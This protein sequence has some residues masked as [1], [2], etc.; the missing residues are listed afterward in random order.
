MD[1]L[2]EAVQVENDADKRMAEFHQIQ[3]IAARDLPI[4]PLLELQQL[5]LFDK[6]VHDHTTTFDGPFSNLAPIWLSH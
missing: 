3:K 1:R 4:F 6:K 5:T 2:L